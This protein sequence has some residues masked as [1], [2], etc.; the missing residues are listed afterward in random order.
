MGLSVRR[1]VGVGGMNLRVLRVWVVFKA[2]KLDEVIEGR[3]VCRT[4]KSLEKERR[5][6]GE[7]SR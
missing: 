6:L 1:A 3:S 2:V 7:G 4:E 5:Q